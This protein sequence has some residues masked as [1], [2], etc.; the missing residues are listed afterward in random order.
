[1]FKP[2]LL[3]ALT[4]A[5]A[6]VTA[7]KH[8]QAGGSPR[9]DLVV[10]IEVGGQ[11]GRFAV[12]TKQRAPYPAET[13]RLEPLRDRL[14]HWG[15][16]L[17]HIPEVTEGQG[18][19]LANRGWSWAD[20]LGNYDIRSPGLILRNRVPRPRGQGRRPSTPFPY[21]WAGLQVLRVLITQPANQLRTT[22][23]AK[24]AEVSTPRASQVLHQLAAHDFATKEQDGSWNVDRA[25]LL[26]LFLA[27]YPGPGG[28][29]SWFFA[30]DTSA[31][32]QALTELSELELVFSGDFAADLIVPHRRPSHLVVYIGHGSIEETDILVPTSSDADA[33]IDVIRP[34]DTSVFP[35]GPMRAALSNHNIP[36]ADPTQVAWDLQRFG[37][38]DRLEQLERLKAWILG[39]H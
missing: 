37:G 5:G 38:A 15:T 27:E 6:T 7:V 16:P 3:N 22:V 35:V 28:D 23:I 20:D 19:A 17:L 13:A 26:E 9:P 36:L 33:N 1:V 10:D 2:Y 12:E 30:L 31:A 11:K 8:E 29:H 21:G 25:S 4:E 18:R 34:F 39:S 14:S 24:R 32:V